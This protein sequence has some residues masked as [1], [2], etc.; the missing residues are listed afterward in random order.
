MGAPSSRPSTSRGAANARRRS[1]RPIEAAPNDPPR[2]CP[3]PLRTEVRTVKSGLLA[4]DSS[5]SKL[6]SNSKAAPITVRSVLRRS[7][8]S[9]THRTHNNSNASV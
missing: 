3:G 8:G 2:G 9:Q 1:H 7:A 6:P 4:A 5:N